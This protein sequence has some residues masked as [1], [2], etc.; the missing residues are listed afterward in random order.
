MSTLLKNF[1]SGLLFDA[2]FRSSR[3]IFFGKW[4]NAN[5]PAV[6]THPLLLYLTWCAKIQPW[7]FHSFIALSLSS[8]CLWI[9]IMR[10]LQKNFSYEFSQSC[11]PKAFFLSWHPME[12]TSEGGGSWSQ[13]QMQKG[14]P[15]FCWLH[16]SWLWTS[17]HLCKRAAY[18]PEAWPGWP[19]CCSA[20]PKN[21]WA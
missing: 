15:S 9:R 2:V 1:K 14:L 3:Q 17:T 8:I 7:A 19:Y 16:S 5:S 11:H 10:I 18:I 13:K 4:H 21:L 12:K 6:R 20:L